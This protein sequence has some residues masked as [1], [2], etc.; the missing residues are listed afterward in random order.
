MTTLSEAIQNANRI[1]IKIGSV[2]IRDDEG[3]R[4]DW[5]AA[6]AQDILALKKSGKQIVVVSSGAVALGRKDVGIDYTTAPSDI[7]LALKQAASAV[8]Q[9]HVFDAYHR[10]FA[11]TGMTAAQV[12]LTYNHSETPRM[13]ANTKAALGALMERG[14]IPVINENDVT[15]TAEIRYGDNDRLAAHVA[16]LVSADMVLLLS[17]VDGLYTADPTEDASAEHIPLVTEITP[18][19]IAMAAEAKPGLSTGGMQSKLQAA[20]A[21]AKAGRSLG[22]ANGQALGALNTTVKG[23]AR[24][25]VFLP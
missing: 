25:T 5:F 10:H 24:G 12:L 21:C 19:H 23:K 7:P 17:T 4:E 3:I 15:S 8:G 6:L 9:Y 1:V 16:A 14:I 11:Q 2:L 13:E 18:A 22:I 20:I